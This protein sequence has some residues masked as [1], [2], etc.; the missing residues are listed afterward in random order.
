[1]ARVGPQSELLE[2]RAAKSELSER[3]AGLRASLNA[4]RPSRA[5]A[6][7][8]EA[9]VTERLKRQKVE[10]MNAELRHALVAQRRFFGTLKSVFM[11]SAV[12]NAVGIRIETALRMLVIRR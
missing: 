5:V 11:G 3:L 10:Q 9:A 1:M 7:A 4:I 8:E 2:L 6:A 12:A